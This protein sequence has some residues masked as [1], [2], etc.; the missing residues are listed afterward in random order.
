LRYPNSRGCF[1][2]GCEEDVRDEKEE[3]RLMMMDERGGGF[4]SY[5]G[6]SARG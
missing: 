5:L 6:K 2:G 1:G 3:R 4:G